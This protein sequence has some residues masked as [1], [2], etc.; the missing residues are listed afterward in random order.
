M[1]FARRQAHTS[2]SS[3][4]HSDGNSGQLV[5]AATTAVGRAGIPVTV[6]GCPVSL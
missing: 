3:V 2:S 5:A 1:P 4:V 6:T